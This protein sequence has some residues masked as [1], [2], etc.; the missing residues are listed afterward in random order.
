MSI[1]TSQA[2][3]RDLLA[4]ISD[5]FA[6]P[7]GQELLAAEQAKVDAM[8]ASLFGYHLLQVGVLPDVELYGQAPASHRFLMLPAMPKEQPPSDS[9]DADTRSSCYAGLVAEPAA[10]PIVSDCVDAVILHHALDFTASPHQVLRETARVL[11]PGG[12]LII[13]G[14]NPASLWGLWKAC[15][16]LRSA[17]S[18]NTQVPWSGYFIRQRRLNDWL[19]LLGLKEEKLETGFYSPPLGSDQWRQRMSRLE[20]FGGRYCS[21][22]GGFYVC[23][24]SKETLAMTPV[25]MSWQRRLAFPLGRPAQVG[26]VSTARDVGAAANVH[27]MPA[28][29]SKKPHR[30]D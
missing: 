10:M 12:K 30:D 24:A 27:V 26:R 14:F 28:R 21:G 11:R 25:N 15:H 3:T 5:W 22:Q 18:G 23:L 20:R 29:T 19:E 2:D 13:V 1:F 16:W 9:N 17:K 6:T 8:I 7:L 4:A